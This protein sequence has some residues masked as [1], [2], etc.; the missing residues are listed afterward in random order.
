MSKKILG[1]AALN[2]CQAN[3]PAVSPD[4]FAGLHKVDTQHK[5]RF[6]DG[7]CL[8]ANQID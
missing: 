3:T 4:S 2:T 5:T 8:G 6:A 7:S 1:I